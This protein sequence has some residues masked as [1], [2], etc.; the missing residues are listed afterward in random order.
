L[1][2]FGEFLVKFVE[3][4]FPSK[5]MKIRNLIQRLQ[6]VYDVYKAK[7][8]SVLAVTEAATPNDELK[9]HNFLQEHKITFMVATAPLEDK[10]YAYNQL[11]GKLFRRWN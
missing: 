6:Q 10:M 4:S 2:C 1:Y 7:G 8:F 3:K 11:I 5:S 9:I